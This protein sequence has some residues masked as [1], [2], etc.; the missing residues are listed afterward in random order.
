MK[1][2]LYGAHP[3]VFSYGF[4]A[5]LFYFKLNKRP[6]IYVLY[7]QN[8][9]SASPH[10]QIVFSI[11]KL[12]LVKDLYCVFPCHNSRKAVYLPVWKRID[13]RVV[14]LV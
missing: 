1:T 10:C 6:N 5:V 12:E 8:I 4:S 14:L 13:R 7:I 11:R 3:L 2:E 9:S